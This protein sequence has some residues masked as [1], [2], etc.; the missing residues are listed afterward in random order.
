VS[1]AT[2][3]TGNTGADFGNTLYNDHHFHYGYHILAA[4]ILGYLDPS[5]VKENREYVNILVRDVANP[6]SQ[7][8]FFPMWRNFDWYH[9]HSWAH[10]LY[11]AMDGKVGTIRSP[12]FSKSTRSNG[13]YRTRNL[14]QKT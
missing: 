6:S 11:A 4:S 13:C 9:G 10:G 8:S 1:S 12:F 3:V 2:Y 5:W 14:A 7:D